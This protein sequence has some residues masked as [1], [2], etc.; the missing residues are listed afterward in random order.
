MR[1]ETFKHK[2]NLVLH[3]LKL[4]YTQKVWITGPP[5]LKISE[6]H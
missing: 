2:F 4:I 3:I 1:T 5:S 6:I